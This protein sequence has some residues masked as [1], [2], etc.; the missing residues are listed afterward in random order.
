MNI[1]LTEKNFIPRFHSLQ[2]KVKKLILNT[3]ISLYL[4]FHLCYFTK[5]KKYMQ[6]GGRGLFKIDS[7]LNLPYFKVISRSISV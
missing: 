7:I 3:N 1:P 6:L 2:R 5:L 4:R